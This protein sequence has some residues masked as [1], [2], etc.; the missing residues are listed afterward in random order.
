VRSRPYDES[1][2]QWGQKNL[3]KAQFYIVTT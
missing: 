3:G 2:S 1:A